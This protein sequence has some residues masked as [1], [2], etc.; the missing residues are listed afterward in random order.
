MTAP[1]ERLVTQ[2]LAPS[3]T[4]IGAVFMDCDG[5]IFDTNKLKCD[6]YR[7]ALADAPSAVVEDLVAYH[8]RTGGMSRYLKIERFYRE[9]HRVPLP[10]E[11]IAQALSRYGAFCEDGYSRM[12]ARAESLAFADRF[13]RDRVWVVSGGDERELRGVFADHGIARHFAAIHGS[14]VTKPVH[15]ARILAERGLAAQQ[16]LFVGDGGGDW[17]AAKALGL[18]FVYLREMSEW[19]D[20][21]KV[22]AAAIDAGANAAIAADWAELLAAAKV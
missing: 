17:D 4:A 6:A 20:G 19:R 7:Y 15:I 9:M 13:G 14:P 18:P 5:V 10:E 11:A 3:P 2:R 16:A 1:L 12:K 8:Q 21:A 22:L